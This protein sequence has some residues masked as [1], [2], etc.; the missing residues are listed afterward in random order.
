MVFCRKET[1]APVL[2]SMFVC[3]YHQLSGVGIVTS[4]T[5]YI[6]HK[7]GVP[8]PKLVSFCA[9]GLGFLLARVVSS[10]LVEVVGRKSLYAISSAGICVSH[11][12]MG[13]MF[14]LVKSA[15]PSSDDFD[16]ATCSSTLYPMAI[17]G[18]VL[19]AFSFGLGAGPVTWIL[20]SEYLPLRIKGIAG[21]LSVLCNR[22]TA[23]ILTGTFLSFSKYV[24]PWAPWFTLASI[25]LAGFV[26]II[27]FVVE[28]KGKTLEEVQHL[29][30]DRILHVPCQK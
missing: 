26:V 20:L 14:F 9:A 4:Y 17:T 19:F 15:C 22:V 3:T 21:G 8:N 16:A 11:L 13:I 23:V 1:L 5:G 29:F 28:T 24:G 30:H 12:I 7:S 18:I 2:L 27:L 25:N 6:L 10:F